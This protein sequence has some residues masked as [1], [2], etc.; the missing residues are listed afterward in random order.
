MKFVSSL[1]GLE[2]GCV[3]VCTLVCMQCACRPI[4][5]VCACMHKCIYM[6]LCM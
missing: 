4:L 3:H 1:G 6:Y 5:C 2:N